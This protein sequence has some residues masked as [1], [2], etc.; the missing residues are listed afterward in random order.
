M[1]CQVG[2]R[3]SPSPGPQRAQY[4]VYCTYLR[5]AL[6][7]HHQIIKHDVELSITCHLHYSL[8]LFGLFRE[9]ADNNVR[10]LG[11]RRQQSAEDSLSV[12]LPTT[13][14]NPRQPTHASRDSPVPSR[15][16]HMRVSPWRSGKGS[17]A[18][19]PNCLR[20]PARRP[21]D[22]VCCERGAAAE[23]RAPAKDAHMQP[24]SPPASLEAAVERG[25]GAPLE[26]TRG[27][28]APSGGR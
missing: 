11:C 18:A 13:E 27:G 1:V 4:E 15:P 24:P 3:A 2:S 9:N 19:R 17:H 10:W 16:Q 8:S 7:A 26:I 28:A 23:M 12:C 25:A 5:G 20:V 22:G 14:R 6:P 21:P